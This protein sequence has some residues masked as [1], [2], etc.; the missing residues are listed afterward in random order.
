MGILQEIIKQGMFTSRNDDGSMAPP[1]PN[2]HIFIHLA[3]VILSGPLAY[4]QQVS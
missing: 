3:S 1:S 4:W 2:P